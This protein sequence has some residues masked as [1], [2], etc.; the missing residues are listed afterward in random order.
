M[1]LQGKFRIQTPFFW[2]W[3]WKAHL[4]LQHSVFSR[5]SR[6]A[7]ELK[8]DLVAKTTYVRL[9][10]NIWG[11]KWSLSFSWKHVSIP[12]TVFPISV[13][14]QKAH[15]SLHVKNGLGYILVATFDP[16]EKNWGKQI[17]WIKWRFDFPF[18]EKEIIV[19]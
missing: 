6:G 16:W 2:F 13:N 11:S 9:T 17:D 14:I 18:R 1:C 10:L 19:I 4:K 15:N 12:C 5:S 3:G 8:L 7:L